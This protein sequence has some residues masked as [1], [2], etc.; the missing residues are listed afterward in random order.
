MKVPAIEGWREKSS[1]DPAAV[2]ALFRPYPRANVGV[3]CGESGL[4]VIDV[5]THGDVDGHCALRRLEAELGALPDTVTSL[6]AHGG[7]HYWFRAPAD[8]VIRNS[9]GLLGPGIDVRGDGG[10]IVAP[11][12]R[13]AD[14]GIYQWDAGGHPDDV[15]IADLPPAWVERLAFSTN[16]VR[17]SEQTEQSAAGDPILDGRRNATLASL[18]GTMRKR[19][20]T[21]P[22]ILA[23]LLTE[24]VE[25][26]SPPLDETEV[27]RIAASIGQYTPGASFACTPRDRLPGFPLDTLPPLLRAHVAE[28]AAAIGCPVDLVALPALAACGASLGNT[29]S[30]DL[31]AGWSERSILW[32]AVIA[33]SGTAKSPALTAALRPLHALQ[34]EA[35]T[36]WRDDHEQWLADLNVWKAT[37]KQKRGLPPDEPRLESLHTTDAT[38]EALGKALETS[39][40]LIVERDE[41]IGFLRSMDA[42]RQRAGADRQQFMTLWNGSPLKIDRVSRGTIFLPS[43]VVCVTGGIQPDMLGELAD[44]AGREDGFLPRFLYAMPDCPPMRW[45]MEEPRAE[46]CAALTERLR[47]A[48]SKGCAVSLDDLAR[49][50][51]RDFFNSANA[52][53]EQGGPLAAFRA[54]APR[55]VT[56]LALVLHTLAAPEEGE[57]LSLI[58]LDAAIA[59]WDYFAA[60]GEAALSAIRAARAGR[61]SLEQRVLAYLRSLNG[62]WASK[63][64][65]FERTGG[66]VSAGELNAALTALQD[67]ELIEREPD[68]QN[69]AGGRPAERWRAA[70]NTGEV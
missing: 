40:G 29:W 9:A 57:P 70:S 7:A 35:Y 15:S 3:A 38:L 13:L 52:S 68:A 14:G 2:R 10:Y 67:E 58:T 47:T 44:E 65:L 33:R 18:A 36:R 63:R 4:V 50:R 45:Q 41:L 60:H 8:R 69:G 28:N 1:A 51:F 55:H 12:S 5:D 49:A 17:A 48:R 34:A 61:G 6:T 43:P 42:Y 37:P 23:A 54:K 26:C 31:K 24:N 59:L 56:R 32:A 25:R 22:A 11:G 53:A 21:E 62:G 39:N 20:M 16:S 46:T 19:G 66:H 27:R 30:L 64:D